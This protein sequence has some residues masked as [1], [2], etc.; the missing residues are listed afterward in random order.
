MKFSERKNLPVKLSDDA[1]LAPYSEILE[2]RRKAA[3]KRFRQLSGKK[4]MSTIDFLN[5][6]KLTGEEKLTEIKSN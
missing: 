4:R 6:V 2:C 3:E 5:G 1:F